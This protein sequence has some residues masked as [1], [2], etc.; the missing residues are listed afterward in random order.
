MAIQGFY[1][2][3]RP[4]Q[5]E[6]KPIYW[7]ARKEELNRRVER[8]RQEMIASGEIDG[9]LSSEQVE[10]SEQERQARLIGYDAS[11][12]VR[13]AFYHGTEHLLRQRERGI[14]AADR[15]RLI[16]RLLLVLMA[17]GFVIWFFFLR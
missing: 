5:F 12:R 11:K 17:L 4:R 6:H 9:E 10:L 7:D 15:T 2:Q 1:R 13:G 14:D 8:I 3:R 16:I